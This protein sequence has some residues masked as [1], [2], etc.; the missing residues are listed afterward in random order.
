MSGQFPGD[1]PKPEPGARA[2]QHSVEQALNHTA[3]AQ[4]P[5]TAEAAVGRI[6]A[7][8][9]SLESI[10]ALAEAEVMEACY[11]IRREHPDQRAFAAYVGE[12]LA[13][14]ITPARAWQ[15]ADVWE[16]GRRHRPVRE[17]A[18][19]EPRKAVNFVREF[20][21]AMGEQQLSVPLDEADVEIAEL[22]TSP[23][24]KFRAR[25]REMVAAR[26]APRDHHPDDLRRIGELEAERD[27]RQAAQA[28]AD[29]VAALEAAEAA[30]FEAR[31]RLLD[32]ELSA[33][34]KARVLK[35]CDRGVGSF[36]D[37]TFWIQKKAAEE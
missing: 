10:F 27:E 16:V 22:L 2:L 20:I 6:R 3:R 12:R 33:R 14:V 4:K 31:T 35:V 28:P 21:E 26:Q 32:V 23:P 30:L 11:V 7:W 1:P 29:A 15:Y 5:A 37:I 24:R 34:A 17:L 36:D 8:R 13:G 19:Q 18:L 25:L 9:E